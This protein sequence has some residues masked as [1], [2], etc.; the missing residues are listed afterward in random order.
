MKK[1]FLTLAIVLS[2]SFAFA[3]NEVL[4]EKVSDKRVDSE[5]GVC[6]LYYTKTDKNGNI[7]AQWETYHIV[8]N[9]EEC[10][11]LAEKQEA[12]ENIKNTLNPF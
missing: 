2:G 6:T 12:I 9:N 7:I 3:N 11:K 1:L 8:K 5:D 4:S 10:K